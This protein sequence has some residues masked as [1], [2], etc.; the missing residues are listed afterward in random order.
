MSEKDVREDLKMS[1]GLQFGGQG[2]GYQYII[3]IQVEG[4][5]V[6]RSGW[7]NGKGIPESLGQKLEGTDANL[8]D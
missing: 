2:C 5:A 4:R 6:Q 8:G 3:T 7:T 1:P